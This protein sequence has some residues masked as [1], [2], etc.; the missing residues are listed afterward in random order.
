MIATGTRHQP[1]A[2]APDGAFGG[3]VTYLLEAPPDHFAGRDV[4]VIGGGDSGT[5]DALEIAR[6][7]SSVTLVHRSEALTA[8]HDIVEQ[9]RHEP[10]IRELSGWEL[11][12][13]EGGDRLEAVTLVRLADGERR[14]VQAG[15]LVVKIARVP[16]TDL[17]RDQLELDRAGA[18]VV[19]GDLQ[20]SCAGVFAAGDVV[21]GCVRAHR[22]RDGSRL[23]RG[24]IGA[25]TPPGPTVTTRA[26]DRVPAV[27]EVVATFRDAL[28]EPAAAGTGWSHRTAAGLH[29]NNALQWDR[30]DAARRDHADD[31]AV[32]DAKRD[33][34]V[35]NAKR[36]DFVEAIDAALAAV[37]DQSPSAPPTTESPGMVFDRLSVLVIRI[38]CTE[39]AAAAAPVERD[40][41]AARLPVL[42][43]QLASLQAALEALFD[44]VRAGR[45]RFVPY[46]SLKLYGGTRVA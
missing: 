25:P 28:A 16:R 22:S 15:G 13:L 24:P 14:R 20:T 30:E 35:L 4:V 6:A 32:A 12:S 21:V 41:Y 23:A 10:R 5:L 31:H 38:A 19:D 29:E 36:H 44:D 42:H 3:D 37:I 40:L 46:Q 34:D 8:R 9:V 26:A 1:L 7:G 17:F 33:I 11:E 43:A 27:A 2:A 45:K 18:I 39:D